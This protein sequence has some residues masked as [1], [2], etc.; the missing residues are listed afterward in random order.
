MKLA[1]LAVPTLVLGYVMDVPGLVIAGGWWIF[2]GLLVR[3]HA[4]RIDAK[5]ADQKTQ[6][7]ISGS[8]NLDPVVGGLQLAFGNALLLLIAV[9]SLLIGILPYGIDDEH[10]GWRWLPI[11]V[12]AIAAVLVLLSLLMLASGTRVNAEGTVHTG[13]DKPATIIIRSVRDTGVKVNQQPRLKFELTVQPDGMSPYAVTKKATVPFAALGSLRPG[14][15]FRALVAGPDK[16]QEMQI[17]WE[18]R[19]TAA[20][21]SSGT[22]EHSAD[23]DPKAR[24]DSLDQLRRD[25]HI[26]DDEYDTQRRRILNS[27]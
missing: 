13:G 23:A 12:G 9:P 18:T 16:P 25:G 21:A 2:T 11:G 8:A 17:D 7:E 4:K 10:L 22:A 27:L 15:G 20:D 24:L 19:V 6:A 3:W 1:V 5:R 26:T 14:D